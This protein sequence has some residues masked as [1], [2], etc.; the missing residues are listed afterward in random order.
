MSETISQ[1]NQLPQA[2]IQEA[3]NHYAQLVASGIERAHDE[4]G[5]DLKSALSTGGEHYDEGQLATREASVLSKS[6]EMASEAGLDAGF[7]DRPM[8]TV[9]LTAAA[10]SW[11]ENEARAKAAGGFDEKLSAERS[12]I[13]ESVL[14]LAGD[15]SSVVRDLKDT[16]PTQARRY[17]EVSE[18]N[19][20][21]KAQRAFFESI[22]DEDR[23]AKITEALA[24]HGEGSFLEKQRKLLGINPDNEKPFNVRVLKFGAMYDFIESGTLDRVEWPDLYDMQTATQEE[25]DAYRQK[26]DV[27]SKLLDSNK[28]YAKEYEDNEVAYNDKFGEIYGA[29]PIAFVHENEDGSQELVIRATQADVLINYILNEKKMPEDQYKRRNLEG[30][31]ATIRHEYGHTQRRIFT[32]Q[33]SQIG[34]IPEER[35]AEFVSGDM[36]GYQDV[37]FL[38]GDLGKATGVDV[39][40]E[41]ETAITQEDAGSAFVSTIANKIGLRNS[42]LLMIAKPLPYE[43]NPDMAQN[44]VNTRC[45]KTEGD[46]SILDGIVR[47][48]LER[49]GD[50]E[51]ARGI[52]EFVIKFLDEGKEVDFIRDSYPSYR[53]MNGLGNSNKYFREAA[54]AYTKSKQSV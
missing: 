18:G 10:E 46:T 44:F 4:H 20:N 35:K 32:G 41:L 25:R 37:K 17:T 7:F 51:F 14:I 54:D 48:N 53:K 40:T 16:D 23:A 49:R 13:A 47:E 21:E 3:Q 38:I 52:G 31:L 6:V 39:L 29:A 12:M 30:E 45:I 26:S 8:N 2:E 50:E 36:N 9:L 28:A 43:K 19:P 11:I 33:H 42:L 22:S 15:K 24:A 5:F 1:L 34:L 27:G